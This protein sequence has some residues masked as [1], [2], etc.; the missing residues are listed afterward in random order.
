VKAE[1]K[2]EEFVPHQGH[3]IKTDIVKDQAPPFPSPI[4]QQT[5]LILAL[6][7]LLATV[8][9]ATFV[10][11]VE[12]TPA[13]STRKTATSVPACDVSEN[14]ENESENEGELAL[15]QAERESPAR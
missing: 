14:S 4:L 1:T 12:V 15:D 10:A 9:A 5:M 8:R 3:R 7:L 13:S 6:L 11:C 2:K